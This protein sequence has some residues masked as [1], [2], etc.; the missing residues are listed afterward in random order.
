V[1]PYQYPHNRKAQIEIMVQ[2]VLHEGISTQREPILI[3]SV[4]SKKKKDG[5]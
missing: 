3:S 1:K 2:D 5:T 4:I